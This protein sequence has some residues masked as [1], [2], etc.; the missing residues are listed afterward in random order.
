VVSKFENIGRVRELFTSLPHAD[1]ARL[2]LPFAGVHFR[3][4]FASQALA[5]MMD[6]DYGEQD[7]ISDRFFQ[8]LEKKVPYRVVVRTRDA[9]ELLISDQVPWFHLAGRMEVGECRA[10][11]GGEVAYVG[12]RIA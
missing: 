1:L 4:S 11:P 7:R 3:R 12:E 2:D 9:S 10:L 5:V 6:A 8:H